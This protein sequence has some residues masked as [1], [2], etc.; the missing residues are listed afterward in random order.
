MHEISQKKN[1]A[2]VKQNF[3]EVHWICVLGIL[4]TIITCLV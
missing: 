2:L 4:C 1:V 3:I